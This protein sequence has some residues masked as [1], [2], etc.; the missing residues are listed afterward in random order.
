MGMHE[1]AIVCMLFAWLLFP[2]F[3]FE[4][5]RARKVPS[6]E[7]VRYLD[8]HDPYPFRLPFRSC[9]C[10][11]GFMKCTAD[12]RSMVIPQKERSLP[13]SNRTI[14]AIFPIYLHSH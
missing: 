9:Y 10:S 2:F 1:S 5:D 14:K 3:F 11:A 4:R 7:N 6:E 13:L 12:M 8:D